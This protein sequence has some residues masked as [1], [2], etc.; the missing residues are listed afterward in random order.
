MYHGT[1]LETGKVI[2]D[3]Q[4]MEPSRGDHHWLGDGIYFY[5]NEKYAFRWIVIKYTG[6]FKNMRARDYKNIFQE[7]DKLIN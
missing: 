2:I 7:Q 5:D 4:K 6:N 3:S 1:D